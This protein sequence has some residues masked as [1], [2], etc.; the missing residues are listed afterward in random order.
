MQALFARFGLSWLWPFGSPS[1]PT[2][3]QNP[4]PTRTSVAE[5]APAPEPV[6]FVGRR[7]DTMAELRPWM[8]GALTGYYGCR[9][10]V[11]PPPDLDGWRAVFKTYQLYLV[12]VPSIEV[13]PSR[14]HG[15]RFDSSIT[16]DRDVERIPLPGRWML[17]ET[18][19]PSSMGHAKEGERSWDQLARFVE[20]GYQRQTSHT[21]LSDTLLPQISSHFRNLPGTVQLPSVEETQFFSG[22]L[23]YLGRRDVTD[24]P[25]PEPWSHRY[26][27]DDWEWARNLCDGGKGALVVQPGFS[28]VLVDRRWRD[29]LQRLGR[30][31]TF[32]IVIHL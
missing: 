15:L 5:L 12:Y 11:P 27:R 9:V 4:T 13:R 7:P 30:N 17:F 26:G 31:M 22:F 18:I 3:S 8:E 20:V 14:G 23:E 16:S 10:T 19:H 29:H 21:Y 28:G 25:V 32:R 6:R 1:V 24:E 2:E